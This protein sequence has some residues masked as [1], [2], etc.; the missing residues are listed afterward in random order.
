MC[1]S[2]IIFKLSYI[3]LSLFFSTASFAECAGK[4]CNVERFSKGAW[5]GDTNM[6]GPANRE[7]FSKAPYSTWFSR[8]YDNYQLDETVIE[9][10]KRNYSSHD[11]DLEISLFM[12][13][14]CSDSKKQTPRLYKILDKMNFDKNNFSINTLGI[15]PQE[16]RR[17]SDGVAEKDL[18]IYRV[19]TI[20]V[21]RNNKELGRIVE[22]P[23]KSL[24][25]DLLT[26]LKGEPYAQA[27]HI[28]EGEVNRHLE[29]QG[30][31]EFSKNL[32]A[33]TKEFKE[34]GI[35]EHELDSYIAYTLL[36][37][38]RYKEAVVVSS[39]MLK[40][41]PT[42]GH[43]HMAL[44]SAYELLGEKDLALTSYKMAFLYIEDKGALDVFR[45]ALSRSEAFY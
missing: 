13:T 27:R 41:F 23:A 45:I 40:I 42:A 1:F 12:G 19:P 36:Y 35:R 18:N 7:G 39:M 29:K 4:Q 22:S 14:W 6:I 16:F 38:K 44:A 10:I 34:K 32:E 25:Q 31:I 9:E 26:I 5:Y 30:A 11:D 3:A 24:E 17:T 15:T 20:I 8:G 43:L 21:K 37:S 28:L 2:R 33:L